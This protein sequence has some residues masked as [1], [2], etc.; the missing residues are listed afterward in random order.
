MAPPE[1]IAVGGAE[2]PDGAPGGVEKGFEQ[3]AAPTALRDPL[4]G[5][6]FG[7]RTRLPCRFVQVG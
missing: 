3:G 7:R 2:R 5:G 6:R 1:N 4:V